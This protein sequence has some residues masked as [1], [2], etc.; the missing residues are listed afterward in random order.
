MQASDAAQIW[1]GI[2]GV[3]TILGVLAAAYIYFAERRDRARFDLKLISTIVGGEK[4]GRKLETA[5]VQVKV[6]VS[7]PGT[8]L[9]KAR[10]TNLDIAGIAVAGNE[11]F[12]T[13]YRFPS[14]LRD[15]DHGKEWRECW[16]GPL[17][18]DGEEPSTSGYV[19][20][21][22]EI[23]PGGSDTMFYEL[24]VPCSY[25]AIKVLVKIPRVDDSTRDE[26]KLIS[27]LSDVCEGRVAVSRHE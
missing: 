19:W 1:Q 21:T 4:R 25:S 26:V 12:G 20:E 9:A 24:I 14:L 11:R 22:T 3:V 16:D 18:Q 17:V 15:V 10:C 27:P 6:L 8:R 13:E 2:A 23:E 5:L 7:N